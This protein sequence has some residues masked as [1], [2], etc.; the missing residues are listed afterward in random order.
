MTYI[1]SS[2]SDLLGENRQFFLTFSH[3]Y[4]ALTTRDKQTDRQTDR[5]TDRRFD[6]S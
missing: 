1:V 2:D 5:E 3:L 4:S 6:H